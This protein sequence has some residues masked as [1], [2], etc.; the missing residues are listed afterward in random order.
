MQQLVTGDV[1]DVILK[2]VSITNDCLNKVKYVLV[3][4][5]QCRYT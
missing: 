2:D 4:F 5:T 1:S 3:E